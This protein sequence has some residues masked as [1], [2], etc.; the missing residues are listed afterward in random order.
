MFVDDVDPFTVENLVRAATGGMTKAV[1]P[2]V[3]THNEVLSAA[4][5]LLDRTMRSIR[6]I[7][8]PQDR[9]ENAQLIHKALSEM[10]TDHG[11]VPS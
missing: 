6:K 3:T 8:S 1:T 11:H 9:F 2:N 10:L 7:Q 4:F 5:T